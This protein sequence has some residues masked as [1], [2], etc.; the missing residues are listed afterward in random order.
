MLNKKAKVNFWFIFILIIS[1]G[2]WFYFKDFKTAAI[3]F[4]GYAVIRI[5]ANFF[6]KNQ[7]Y[8]EDYYG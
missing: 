1:I 2:I 5:I 3:V 4:F 8:Q 6:K 7:E